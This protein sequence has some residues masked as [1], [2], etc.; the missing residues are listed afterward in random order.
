MI[1]FVLLI[2]LLCLYKIRFA[3][4]DGAI[5]D[6]YMSKDG[7]AAIKGLFTLLIIVSHFSGYITPTNAL[8]QMYVVFQRLLGQLVVALFLFYSGYGI[9]ESIKKKGEGYVAKMPVHRVLKL[10]CHFALAVL[11]FLVVQ[12]LLGVKFPAKT[13][14]LSLVGWESIGNSNWYVFV[15]MCAYII[16]WLGFSLC[17]SKKLPALILV[18]LLSF[19]LIYLLK[20]YR[21]VHWYDT[22]LCYPAGMWY[23][24]FKEKIDGSF[25]GHSLRCYMAFAAVILCFLGVRLLRRPTVLLLAAPLFSL[26]VVLFTMKVKVDNKILRFFGEHLFEVYML[27]RLPMIALEKTALAAGNKYLYF[28][29]CFAITIAIAWVFK[30][31]LSALDR[32]TFDRKTA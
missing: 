1:I 17:K 3:G 31:L 12:T 27:Q 2:F 23:S 8:D 5:F 22:F 16:S 21:F 18:T 15:I 26:G 7:T 25:R 32:L 20:T 14:L 11:L 6:D 9:L 30:K 24:Y 19:G 10:L 13:V 4:G 29:V 28:A